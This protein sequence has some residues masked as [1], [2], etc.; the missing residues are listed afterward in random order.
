M[1][2]QIDDGID[3]VNLRGNFFGF[4][5]GLNE[6]KFDFLL[7]VYT[8]MRALLAKRFMRSPAVRKMKVIL[9]QHNMFTMDRGP[10]QTKLRFARCRLLYP[11]AAACVCVS[12]GVAEEMASIGLLPEEKIH[13]I[14]NPVVTD[15]LKAQ[16]EAPIK[17]GPLERFGRD[18]FLEFLGVGRLGSQKDFATLI[19]A[20]A[21]YSNVRSDARLTVLGEGRQRPTLEKLVSELGISD[22]VSMPGYEANPY[23][24]MKRASLMVVTSVYEGFCNVVAEALACGC[25]VVSTD[26][27]SGP[28][29]ILDGGNYGRLARVG[30]PEDIARKMREAVDSPLP[31]DAL[32]K[33]AEFFSETRAVDGYC[34]IFESLIRLSASQ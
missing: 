16:M 11:W 29:E 2:E 32:I 27:P 18:G 1:L 20:F 5:K 21:I 13:V 26:C 14:Y 17:S 10:I 34:E 30:D 15:R 24:F 25:N 7:P 23:P 33:R 19:R 28:S 31:R 3:V 12:R 22:R 6:R 9:S 8:S 4:F